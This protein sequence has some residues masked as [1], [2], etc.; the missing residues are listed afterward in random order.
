MSYEYYTNVGN[1]FQIVFETKEKVIKAD[2]ATIFATSMPPTE[3][4]I[5]IV[6]GALQHENMR[7]GEKRAVLGPGAIFYRIFSEKHP[8]WSKHELWNV[9]APQISGWISITSD[10]V[11]KL[12]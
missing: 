10:D 12:K 5:A 11:K 9:I 2:M 8:K 7:L 1:F 3:A 4:E 6:Y